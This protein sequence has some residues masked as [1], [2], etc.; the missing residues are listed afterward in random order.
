MSFDNHI[1]KGCSTSDALVEP[2]PQPG[3]RIPPYITES[4]QPVLWKFPAEVALNNKMNAVAFK[5]FFHKKADIA[6]EI[7]AGIQTEQE[8]L[9][10]DLPGKPEYFNKKVR[11]ISLAVLFSLPQFTRNKVSFCPDI[12]KDRGIPVFALIGS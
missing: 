4:F 2:F 9:I 7:I 3:N 12:G 10:R 5:T 6:S 11:C 1:Y 8:R